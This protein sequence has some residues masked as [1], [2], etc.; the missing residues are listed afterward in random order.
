MNKW[1]LQAALFYSRDFHLSVTFTAD[2][3]QIQN[4]MSHYIRQASFLNRKDIMLRNI[5]DLEIL[6]VSPEASQFF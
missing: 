3:L 2:I 4:V 1:L 5:I 6:C